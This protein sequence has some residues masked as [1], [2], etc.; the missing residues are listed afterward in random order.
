LIAEKIERT[1]PRARRAAVSQFQKYNRVPHT[2]TR[3]TALDRA[4]SL[5]RAIVR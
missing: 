2:A 3:V 5:D 4:V 1:P